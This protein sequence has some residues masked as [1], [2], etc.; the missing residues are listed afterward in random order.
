MRSLSYG[1]LRAQKK[2]SNVENFLTSVG[3]VTEEF[4]EPVEPIKLCLSN[5]ERYA[6]DLEY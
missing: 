2:A 1:R 5:T 3:S 4:I 6:S